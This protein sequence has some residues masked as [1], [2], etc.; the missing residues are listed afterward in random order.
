MYRDDFYLATILCHDSSILPHNL[1]EGYIAVNPA[2]FA[3]RLPLSVVISFF[4]VGVKFQ[5]GIAVNY[6]GFVSKSLFF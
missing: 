6:P 3:F 5:F 4:G 2:P 1:V